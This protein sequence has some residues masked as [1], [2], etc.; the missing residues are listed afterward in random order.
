MQCQLRPNVLIKRVKYDVN[1]NHIRIQAIDSRRIDE[2]GMNP[3]GALIPP[4][5]PVVGKEPPKVVEQ[6]GPR[7][8]GDLVPSN[9]T[10]WV[11]GN[12]RGRTGTVNLGDLLRVQLDTP[13]VLPGKPFQLLND[14]KFCSML[15]VEERRNNYEAQFN[16]AL[17]LLE[18]WRPQLFSG[19][20]AVGGERPVVATTKRLRRSPGMG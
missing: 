4:P 16:P 19:T 14:A 13:V 7:N 6:M 15:P 1:H 9:R 2:I 17:E 5:S 10:R 18:L 11:L 8:A 20:S 12:F 3:A